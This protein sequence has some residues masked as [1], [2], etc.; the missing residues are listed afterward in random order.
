MSLRN[1]AS[2]AKQTRCVLNNGT[3]Y[4]TTFG[5]VSKRFYGA[6]SSAAAGSFLNRDE[7][8]QRVLNVVKKHEKVDAAKVTPDSH[9]SNDLGL[10]SLDAAEVVM[11]VEN[12]FSVEIPDEEAFKLVAIPDIITYISQNPLAK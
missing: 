6:E 4:R 10:D 12:E 1:L 8:T 5:N 9:F 3:I 2:F 11:E 7:V